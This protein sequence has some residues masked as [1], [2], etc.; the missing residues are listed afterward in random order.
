[1]K[2][3]SVESGGNGCFSHEKPKVIP[4]ILMRLKYTAILMYFSYPS[5]KLMFS[6]LKTFYF[7]P[8]LAVF[9]SAENINFFTR[10]MLPSK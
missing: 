5:K 6:A 3:I 10:A 8:C 7:T 9:F 1:V 4:Q 2:K